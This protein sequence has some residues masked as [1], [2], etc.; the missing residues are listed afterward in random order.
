M[1]FSI[2]SDYIRFHLQK[3]AKLM[4][5]EDE[6]VTESPEPKEDIV[7]VNGVVHGA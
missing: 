5:D 3:A 4:A 6:D 1:K 2:L 7:E